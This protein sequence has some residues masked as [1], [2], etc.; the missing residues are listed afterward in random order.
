MRSSEFAVAGVCD[1]LMGNTF[2]LS[3]MQECCRKLL[4]SLKGESLVGR[5]ALHPCDIAQEAS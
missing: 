1:R 2:T 4:V 3:R 5:Q